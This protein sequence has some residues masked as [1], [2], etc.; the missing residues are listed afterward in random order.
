M[1]VT[2]IRNPTTR[3]SGVVI[4]VHGVISSSESCWS[5][6]DK[7]TWPEILSQHSGS[8]GY[9]ICAFS[10]TT[11]AISGTYSIDDAADALWQFIASEGIVDRSRIVFVAHS[12][13]GIVVRSM[14]VD[15]A[16]ELAKTEKTIGLLLVASPSTGAR[17]AT[18]LFPIIAAMNHS[19][20]ML[21]RPAEDNAWLAALRRKFIALYQ[22]KKLHIVGKELVED[23][24]V[25]P[26]LPWIP[27]IVRRIEGDV[28]FA[29]SLRIG[30]STHF[31]ISKPK[32]NRSDQH[33]ALMQFLKKVEAESQSFG[34]NFPK[35]LSLSGVMSA[36]EQASGATIRLV[37]FDAK[38]LSR[39]ATGGQINSGTLLG[40][41][42]AA[43][44]QFKSAAFI[45]VE[46]EVDPSGDVIL[47]KVQK[48]KGV[49]NG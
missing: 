29:D 43:M 42:T 7:V 25:L 26:W 15:R 12:M 49:A 34:F 30:G 11:S 17:W 39:P 36:I 41:V 10:Y 48:G 19:Q 45:E 23:R 1:P 24:F 38:D 32:D 35:G 47:T 22:A 18:L 20:A 4:F 16:A 37:G 21:L 9:G 44:R 27:P 5:N 3:E 33:V 6:R 2:W 14:I 8:G 13:G 40:V 28:F 46:I 31:S